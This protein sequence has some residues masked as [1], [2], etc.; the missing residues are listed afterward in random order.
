MEQM[1]DTSIDLGGCASVLRLL[2]LG[3][4]DGTRM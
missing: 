2:V 1:V 4:C 3:I